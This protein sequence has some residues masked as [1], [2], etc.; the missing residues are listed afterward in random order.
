VVPMVGDSPGPRQSC[1]GESSADGTAA[2]CSVLA[3]PRGGPARAEGSS[4][5]A[6]SAA[7][8]GGRAPGLV[9]YAI[10]GRRSSPSTSEPVEVPDYPSAI[11]DI[12][13]P[14]FPAAELVEAAAGW[15]T[16]LPS[17]QG[18]EGPRW[19]VMVSPGVFAV[20]SK[21]LAKVARTYD[22]HAGFND[23]VITWKIRELGRAGSVRAGESGR[24]HRAADLRARHACHDPVCWCEREVVPDHYCAMEGCP[25]TELGRFRADHGC[26]DHCDPGCPHRPGRGREITEW[27]RKSRSR[28]V[29]TLCELDYGPLVA[30]EGMPGIVTLTYPGNWLRFAPDGPT[31]K[32][33]MKVL[34][35]RWQRAWGLPVLAPWKLEFQ[36]RGA[37][38][39][40][41]FTMIPNGLL[42]DDKRF[43]EWLSETWTDVVFAG[44]D[45]PGERRK[46]LA[47]GTGV[48]YVEGLRSR[49]PRRIAVYFS[50]HGSFVAKDYQNEVPGEWKESGKGPGRFWGY[51]GLEKCTQTVE[52]TPAEALAAARIA[53]RWTRAGD[54]GRGDRGADRC[55]AGSPERFEVARRTAQMGPPVTHEVRAPRTRGGVPRTDQPVIGLAGAQL[56]EV[57]KRKYRKVRRRSRRMRGSRGWVS[58]NDGA[59]F[60]ADV[61]RYLDIAFRPLG[62]P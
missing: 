55:A 7:P 15:F 10:T 6:A 27:S 46:H 42:A 58:V 20:G 3:G 32:A 11:R 56:A 23:G 54:R 52:V 43:K 25:A 1:P 49:D 4:A 35:K 45:D 47:A 28:M 36:R 19:R 30:R 38:H 53:R 39:V 51:W 17:W 41:L 40:H 12:W 2:S 33:H 62:R 61:A 21:D 24:D 57:G 9:T 37:P 8:P 34:R 50:K 31:V 59:A 14:K 26:P 5:G 29:R 16:P 13:G 44:H 18:E 22:R 48:D 60:A